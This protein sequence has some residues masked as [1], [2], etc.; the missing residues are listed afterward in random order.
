VRLYVPTTLR[1]LADPDG[2]AAPSA[3]AVTARLAAALPEE[4]VEGLEFAALLVAADESV[5][6][7]ARDPEAP[8]RR[9]V[10]VADVPGPTSRA[11]PGGLPSAVEPPRLIPWTR[12]VSLHVDDEGAVEDVGLA[13]G[14]AQD[15][16]DRAAE[17]DLLW[18][19][20]SELD[21]L[22]ALAP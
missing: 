9:V 5:E 20:V 15:A 16:L 18:Y 19:D 4:D 21:L 13:A 8:R 17:R 14:G 6:L 3:H 1:A 2:L 11:R 7:L 12:V 22:R 10:A